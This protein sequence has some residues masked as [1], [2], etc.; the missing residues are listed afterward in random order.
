MT[1]LKAVVTGAGGFI[2]SHLTAYLASLDISV[3]G[4]DAGDFDINDSRC[5][6]DL[7]RQE[8]PDQV[9]HLAA[10]ASVA[11]SW[12]DPQRTWV[13]NCLGSV[14]VLD[15]VRRECPGARV[16]LMSTASVFDG[17]TFRRPITEAENP[18]P[19]SPYAA[20]KAAAE[21]AAR[22]YARAYDLDIALVRAF[23]V[24][25]P[26][27]SGAYVLPALAHR[28][29]QARRMNQKTIAAGNLEAVRDFVDV[30][31]VVA[32]L[33]CILDPA[34]PRIP[35]LHLCSGTGTS[36]HEL[37]SMIAESLDWPVVQERDHSLVRPADPQIL[38]G[39]PALATATLEW[40]AQIPLRETIGDLLVTLI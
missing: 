24:V 30:R 21:L 19:R 1:P 31:D 11:D 27:Q 15:A 12:R 39:D 16:L 9:Y 23:N 4:V 37:M 14:T 10:Q 13:T 17:T 7:L 22:Q 34:M 5:L 29:I 32:G 35:L 18:C 40:K 36:I 28:L 20:S 8:Q 38:I 6:R 2:G 33:A 26:G 3:R 25:G